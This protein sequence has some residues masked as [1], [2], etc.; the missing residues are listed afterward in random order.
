MVA[1]ERVLLARHGETEWNVIGR[2][3]GQLDSPLTQR[4]LTHARALADRVAPLSVDAVFASPLGRAATTAAI[5]AQQLNLPVVTLDELAEVNHGTMAALSNTDIERQFPGEL[6]RRAGDLYEWRFPGGESY[7]DAD[8]RAE[9]AV[10]RIQETGCSRPLVVA[11][12][13]IGRMLQRA[14]TG[15][16]PIAALLWNQPHE[17]IIRIDCSTHARTEL[18]PAGPFDS[19]AAVATG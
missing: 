8:R 18:R 4:G 15:V 11:H 10:S 9:I 7:R 19:P 6:S 16:A 14:L 2:R 12:E 17:V 3:Q 1:M 5:C 13:M